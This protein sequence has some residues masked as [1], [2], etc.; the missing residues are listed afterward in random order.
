MTVICGEKMQ[1]NDK[2]PI[3]MGLIR[4]A[5][6]PNF[7]IV[8]VCGKMEN[9]ITPETVSITKRELDVL[10]LLAKGYTSTRIA[11]ELGICQST[12]MDYRKKLHMKFKVN[13]VGELVFKATE[14]H[15]I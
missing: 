10:R 6:L 13:R 4:V 7:V 5:K 8:N 1:K 9:E 3:F 15:L 14:L 11:E 12:V 2:T